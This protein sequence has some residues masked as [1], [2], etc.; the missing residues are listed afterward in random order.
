MTN[1]SD[2]LYIVTNDDDHPVEFAFNRQ[3]VTLTP[4]QS[5][6]V[7][8]EA[9][10]EKLGD[11]RS[12]PQTVRLMVNG[13]PAGQIAS[14]EWWIKRLATYYGTYDP[15]HPE[16][17]VAKMPKVTIKTLEGEDPN[18]SFPCSD[19][20]CK[21]LQPDNINQ[22]TE[23]NL[24]RELEEMKR[25]Q[26]ALESLLKNRTVPEPVADIK[27]DQPPDNVKAARGQQA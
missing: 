24:R 13:M 16:E 11:P 12:G 15:A 22:S 20:D 19:P 1:F 21:Y 26:K 6:M 14:R 17:I 10:V 7:P 9:I 23:E 8:F 18:F 2:S 25:R 27:E 3:S 5:G 4:G